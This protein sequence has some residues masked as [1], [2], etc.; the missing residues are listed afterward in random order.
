MSSTSSILR[1]AAEKW[2]VAERCGA[3]KQPAVS[4]ARPRA[5]ASPWQPPTE[6]HAAE[7][8]SPAAPHDLFE[9]MLLHGDCAYLLDLWAL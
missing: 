2:S 4:R 7:A 3:L 6:S 5:E 9:L 1:K 8:G